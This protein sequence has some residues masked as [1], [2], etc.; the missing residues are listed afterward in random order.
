MFTSQSLPNS[1]KVFYWIWAFSFPYD[2]KYLPLPENP[3]GI[4]LIGFWIIW[5]GVGGLMVVPLG[6]WMTRK[7]THKDDF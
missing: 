6:E 4:S 3:T 1:I 5:L 7:K 2:Y